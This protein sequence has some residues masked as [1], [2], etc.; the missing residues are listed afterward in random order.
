MLPEQSI[1]T[2]QVV[3]YNPEWPAWFGELRDRVWP[4]VRDIAVAVEHVGSTSVPGL[5]AKP[6]IDL[7]LVIPSRSELPW[8]VLRLGRLGYKHLGD[9]EIPDREAF[10]TLENQPA[11]HLYVCPLDSIALRNHIAL[12]D[13]LR[14]HPADAA[15]YASLK[16]QLAKRFPHDI[17]RYAKSRTDLILSILA[18]YG[19][20]ADHRG[21]L[22][23]GVV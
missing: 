18:Q 1:V 11:H 16:K 23:T 3:D 12:R 14:G 22:N 5:A 20:S 8:I 21:C 17:D 7:D 13:H 15:A 19:L 10:S 6:V 4:S 9:L 2:V